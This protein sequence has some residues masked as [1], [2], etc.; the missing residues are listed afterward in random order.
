VYGL[1]YPDMPALYRSPDC[2]PGG[3]LDQHPGGAWPD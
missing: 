3:P 2:R 1:T